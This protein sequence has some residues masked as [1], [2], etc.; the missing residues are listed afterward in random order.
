LP[1][2][3]YSSSPIPAA[4]SNPLK[5]K[6]RKATEEQLKP[7]SLPQG[8]SGG[9]L[10]VPPPARHAA[11]EM[12]LGSLPQ[13]ESL[14][15]DSSPLPL[16]KQFLNS[17]ARRKESQRAAKQQAYRL[18]QEAATEDTK[19]KM[20]SRSTD[21][22]AAGFFSTTS[23]RRIVQRAHCVRNGTLGHVQVG[24]VAIRR[25]SQIGHE[26]LTVC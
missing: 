24:K 5:R 23:H 21:G 22:K 19:A 7:P 25:R 15:H 11:Q 10:E 14:S 3:S 12:L 8:A 26:M 16:A 1:Q 9:D 6:K 13:A 20:R 18:A 4:E 2:E 17:N